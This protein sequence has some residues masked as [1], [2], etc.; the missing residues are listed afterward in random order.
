MQR[1]GK[2]TRRVTP[3][4]KVKRQAKHR[5]NITNFLSRIRE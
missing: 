1:Q 3:V 4:Q 2:Y 5:M